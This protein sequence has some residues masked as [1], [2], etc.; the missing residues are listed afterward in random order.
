ITGVDQPFATATRSL[1]RPA[2]DLVLVRQPPMLVGITRGGY[3]RVAGER[4]VDSSATDPQV[5]ADEL[6]RINQRMMQKASCLWY[7]IDQNSPS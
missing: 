7:R 6:Y 2:D 4:L 3:V 1:L 5:G